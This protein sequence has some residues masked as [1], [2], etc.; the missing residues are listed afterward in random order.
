MTKGGQCVA[1]ERQMMM[2]EEQTASVWEQELS[3]GLTVTLARDFLRAYEPSK[4]N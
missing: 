1:C 2:Q 3:G 4:A